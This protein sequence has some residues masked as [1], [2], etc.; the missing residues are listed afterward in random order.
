M[1]EKVKLDCPICSKQTNKMWSLKSLVMLKCG[2]RT[3]VYMQYNKSNRQALFWCSLLI[4]L[5]IASSIVYDIIRTTIS[6]FLWKKFECEKAPIRKTNDFTPLRHFCA[7]IITAFVVFCLLNFILLVGFGLVYVFVR[8]KS[9][10]KKKLA[11]NCPDYLI[12]WRVLT[13]TTDV[14]P[15]QP[16]HQEFICTH[17]SLFVIIFKNLFFLWESF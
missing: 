4:I 11:W 5:E 6:I 16:I 14:Y 2:S 3:V 17:L 15:Y 12:Y 9:F 10:C 8:S 7:R 1:Q 13:C